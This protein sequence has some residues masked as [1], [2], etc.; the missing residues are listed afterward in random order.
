[1]SNLVLNIPEDVVS[2]LRLPPAQVERELRTELALALY[3]RQIL[4]LGKARRLAAMTRRDF[5]ELLGERQVPRAY[6]EDDLDEDLAYGLGKSGT[7]RGDG[8]GGA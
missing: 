8:E 7:G 3:A 4:P 2:A 5:E 1:M 6:T